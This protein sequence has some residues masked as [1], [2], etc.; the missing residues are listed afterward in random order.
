MLSDN[1]S[2][3]TKI[4]ALAVDA[5]NNANLIVNVG[6]VNT[7]TGGTSTAKVALTKAGVGTSLT[8]TGDNTYTGATTVSGGTLAI[9]AADRIADAFAL[10]APQLFQI[11]LN[12]GSAYIDASGYLTAVPEV[13]SFALLGGLAAL[14]CVVARRRK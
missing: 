7:Y 14:G 11:T 9:G 6:G 5:G 13:G 2:D 10:T 4:L 12:G 1:T 3:G 8:L